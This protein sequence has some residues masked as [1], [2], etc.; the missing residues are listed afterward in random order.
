VLRASPLVVIRDGNG[1]PK[2]DGFLLH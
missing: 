1:Y 2:S